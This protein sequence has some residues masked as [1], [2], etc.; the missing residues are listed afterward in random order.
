MHCKGCLVCCTIELIVIQWRAQFHVSLNLWKRMDHCCF[1]IHYVLTINIDSTFCPLLLY[2]C[3]YWFVARGCS[4]RFIMANI[5]LR[6][7]SAMVAR[8]PIPSGTYPQLFGKLV[9]SS[10]V[11]VILDRTSLLNGW[12]TA[13]YYRYNWLTKQLITGD[14]YVEAQTSHWTRHNLI[15]H[16]MVSTNHTPWID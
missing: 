10:V 12:L 9:S 7:S 8:P 13:S 2:H 16:R 4:K 5:D 14:R 1:A 15:D 11:P 3:Y 6:V